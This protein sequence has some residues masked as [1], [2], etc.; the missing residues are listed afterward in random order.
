MDAQCAKCGVKVVITDV[1]LHGYSFEMKPGESLD[2][3]C[4]VI[5]ERSEASKNV[6][7]EAKCPHL[8]EAIEAR[9]ERFRLEHP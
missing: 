7:E 1:R 9:I 3:L 8:K 2:Q 6:I 5:I 4:P